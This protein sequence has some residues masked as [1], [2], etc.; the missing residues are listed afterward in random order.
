M[1]RILL[2]I[3]LV[4]TLLVCAASLTLTHESSCIPLGGTGC[5]G[6]NG[7]CC[8]AGNPYTGTMRKCVNTGSFS[9]PVYTCVN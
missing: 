5:Q 7:M 2:T 3:L 8:R 6:N 1:K 4:Y 9:N